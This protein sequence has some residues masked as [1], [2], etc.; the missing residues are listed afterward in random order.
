MS[1]RAVR[2]EHLSPAVEWLRRGLVVAFPTDTFYGLA[3]DPT[4]PSAVET[5]FDLKGRDARAAVPLVAASRSQVEG[6]CGPL[7]GAASRLADAFWPGPLSLIVEAP[8]SIAAAVHAG[9]GTVAVRVPAYSV[10]RGLCEAWGA[11]LTATSANRSGEPAARTPDTL[12]ALADDPRLLIVDGGQ[13]P[14]GLAS[15]VVDARRLPIARV[16]AGAIAWTRV[17]ESLQE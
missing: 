1:A 5:L 11:P 14:G 2:P 3:V 8:P 16:R 12:G 17:L 10:A 4:V 7:G 6:F 15:T 9:H 13:T